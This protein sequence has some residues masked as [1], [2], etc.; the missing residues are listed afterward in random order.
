[1]VNLV[2]GEK[3]FR[4]VL[5][6]ILGGLIGFERERNNRPAG[7]RTHTLVAISGC[8]AILVNYEVMMVFGQHTTLD[9][10]RM[11][12]YVISGIGFLGGGT[13]LKEGNSV[14]GLT[15]AA[16]L[17]ASAMVGLAIGI[18]LYEVAIFSVILIIFVLYV[19]NKLEWRYR[20]R[21]R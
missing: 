15:T 11:G 10:G 14:K 13:I 6:T 21:F 4:L 16:S 3:L 8:M 9:P 18:G 2:I 17:W 1:M 19:V 20:Q 5:S 12:A 7:L